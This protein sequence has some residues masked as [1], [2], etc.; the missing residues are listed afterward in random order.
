MR[1]IVIALC[2][3]LIG[4]ALIVGV[5][6]GGNMLG[7]WSYSFFAP[8]YEN[9]RRNVF[10]NTQSYVEGKRQ[11]ITKYYD[12][13]RR[14]DSTDKTVIRQLVLQDFANFNLDYLTP[15]QRQWYNEITSY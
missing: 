10:E 15:V 4:L 6:W 2:S 12:E 11:S 8:K 7:L 3:I 5:V 1:Q 14:S 13:Y 9:A